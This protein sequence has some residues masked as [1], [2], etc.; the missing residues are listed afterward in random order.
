MN[1][2]RPSR[3]A[4]HYDNTLRLEQAERTRE[5]ILESAVQLL[6]SEGE[7][8]ATLAEV[9]RVARVS[10]PTLYRHFG[11][12]EKLLEELDAHAQQKLGFPVLPRGADDLPAHIPALFGKF[13]EHAPV[14][15][16]TLN[17]G[18][19][20]EVRSRGRARRTRWLR[21]LLAAAAPDLRRREL[22]RLTG[23]LRVLSSWE[24]FDVLTGELGLS[25]EEAGEAVVW[26]TQTLIS[27]ARGGPSGKGRAERTDGAGRKTMRKERSR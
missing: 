27:E 9:A 19:G 17:S 11:S 2:A 26:A 22:D 24:A 5:R 18:V 15:R 16:A 3:K 25:T 13:E 6:A 14:L 10:E 7:R 4:R 12:R 23:V 1:K 21:E 8:R 20:K